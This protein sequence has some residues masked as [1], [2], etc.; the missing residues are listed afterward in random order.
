MRAHLS[1]S[2]TCALLTIGSNVPGRR[3]KYSGGFVTVASDTFAKQTQ[4]RP[5][6][7]ISAEKFK[8]R[9]RSEL[10]TLR[11]TTGGSLA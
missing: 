11:D 8:P 6:E 10:Q 7:A 1:M 3:Q 2:Y 5:A 9:N 4:A